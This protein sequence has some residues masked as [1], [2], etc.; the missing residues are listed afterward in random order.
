MKVIPEGLPMDELMR[1]AIH[2]AGHAVVQIALGIGCK[3]VSIIP[4]EATAGTT[5]HGGEDAK[6]ASD[7]GEHDNVATL[8]IYAEDA[9]LLRHA[10]ADYAGAEAEKRSNPVLDWKAERDEREATDRLNDITTDAESIDLLFKYAHR[11]CALLVE[12]YWPEIMAMADLLMEH[13]SLTGEQ[14]RQAFS[15]SMQARRGVNMQW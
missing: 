2:E 10:I 14:A 9:F 12:H 6:P 5:A 7:I 3:G 11:R 15:K 4:A 1:T 8:R 13:R